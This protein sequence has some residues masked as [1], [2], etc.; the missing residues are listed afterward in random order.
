MTQQLALFDKKTV[1]V[2]QAD[3]VLRMLRENE[4]GLCA[5]TRRSQ[6]GG[7]HPTAARMRGDRCR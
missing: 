2:S 7:G 1:K 4:I 3:R 6:T 5:T